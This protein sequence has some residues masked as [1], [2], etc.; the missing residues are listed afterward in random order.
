MKTSTVS[1]LFF[2]II[3][4][5]S[6]CSDVR[7]IDAQPEHLE[8]LSFIP[9]QFQG[10][11]V[12]NNDTVVV[13]DCTINGDSIN[14]NTLVVKSWGNYL[15]VNSLE[16]GVYKLSCAKVVN[17]WNNKNISLEYFRLFDELSLLRSSLG[18]SAILLEEIDK[19]IADKNNPL[20]RI[21]TTDTFHYILD[22]VSVNHFQSLLNNAKSKAVIRIE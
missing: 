9:N 5:L 2:I 11:F 3:L 17:A 16:S 22:D 1:A 10:I 8:E 4:L 7:F 21:D 19:M 13:T 6:S 14:S 20:I 15:F 12:I 18:E